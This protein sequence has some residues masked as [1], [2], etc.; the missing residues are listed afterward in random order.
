MEFKE[1]QQKAV[2]AVKERLERK[3]IS[4]DDEI[5]IIHLMEES[6][7]LAA[8][9]MNRKLKRREMDIKNIGE[10]IADCIIILMNLAEVHEID[11]EKYLLNKI[12]DVRNKLN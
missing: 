3:E 10:E 1:I 2:G 8:Q 12:E 6:G 11:L 9:I 4:W 5:L 7:E